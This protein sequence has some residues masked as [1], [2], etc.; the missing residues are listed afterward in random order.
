M[1]DIAASQNFQREH[2]AS[3]KKTDT[4]S[5]KAIEIVKEKDAQGNEMEA[6]ELAS[7]VGKTN[8]LLLTDGFN[9]VHPSLSLSYVTLSIGRNCR[10]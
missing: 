1:I 5:F 4:K 10:W 9:Q 3:K 6:A 8:K 2:Q 7:S